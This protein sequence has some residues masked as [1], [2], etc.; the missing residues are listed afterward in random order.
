MLPLAFSPVSFYPLAILSLALLFVLWRDVAPA[1]AAWRGF[2]FGLGQFGIGVSWLYVALHTYGQMSGALAILALALFFA[3]LACYS[4]LVGW[5]QARLFRV[6]G[7]WTQILGISALWTLG[8][9]V[10]GWFLTGFPWLAIGYSQVNGPLAGVAPWFG[11]YGVSLAAAVSA[12]LVAQAWRHRAVVWRY[13]GTLIALWFVAWMAGRVDWV[14]PAGAPLRVALV[15][16]DVPLAQKWMP[17]YRQPILQ[18]YMALTFAQHRIDLAVWPEA[19]VPFF[20]DEVEHSF[21]ARLKQTAEAH[22]MEILLG[23]LE[24]RRVGGVVR[25]Y[26]SV[27]GIGRDSGVYRKHHLVPFG[28]YLPLAAQLQWLLDDL[29]IPMSDLSPGPARQPPLRIDGQSVGMSICY[30]DVFGPE[31]MRALPQATLL[32]NVTEDAWYGHSLASY[33]QMEMARMRALEAGRE[34]MLATNTGVTAIIDSHGNVVARAPQFRPWV[35]TGTVTPLKGATPYVN[36]GN[37]IIV[38]LLTV[39]VIG[40]LAV[41]RLRRS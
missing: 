4:A 37:R 17:A 20:R 22:H 6:A 39:V 15:Q 32:A 33:Q 41:P 29:R 27:I 34:M 2:L 3:F 13:V 36:Y 35:L 26:N 25:Y 19:A 18:R 23:I 30:E 38:W 11:I 1:R 14:Q 21:L 12:G 10:R 28:E 40:L 5:L 31:V 8:E 9:W 24:R 7:P 16:G